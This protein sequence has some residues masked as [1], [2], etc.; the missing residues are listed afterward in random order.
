[1]F[2]SRTLKTSNL[3]AIKVAYFIT[4]QS[5]D[6][7]QTEAL[8]CLKVLFLIE[9]FVAAFVLIVKLSRQIINES[10]SN[11]PLLYNRHGML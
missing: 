9:I 4:I 8:L 1:M 3:F 11:E 10:S 7:L 2:S 6:G 5:F